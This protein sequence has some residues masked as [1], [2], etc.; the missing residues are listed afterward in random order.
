[1]QRILKDLLQNNSSFL[2]IPNPV[3]SL[4]VYYNLYALYTGLSNL[5]NL[6][7]IVDTYIDRTKF[8]D[9]IQKTTKIGELSTIDINDKN[10]IIVTLKDLKSDIDGVEWKKTEQGI[11]L[12]I[13]TVDQAPAGVKLK[14]KN[15][16]YDKIILL[17]FDTEEEISHLIN[18]NTELLNQDKLIIFSSNKSLDN[19]NRFY[20]NDN[21]SVG[22]QVYSFMK[23]F[24]IPVNKTAALYLIAGI[25]QSTNNLISNVNANTF[26]ALA[27]LSNQNAN[28]DL[29]ITLANEKIQQT[30]KPDI[31]NVDQDNQKAPKISIQN[32][33]NTVSI[34]QPKTIS[35]ALPLDNHKEENA[36][37]KP[38]TLQPK[39]E[40]VTKGL[41]QQINETNTVPLSPATNV[42]EPIRFEKVK[43]VVHP[44]TPLP[45]AHT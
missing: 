42:P 38:T 10:K 44:N 7:L 3:K 36:P 19:K 28:L 21:S 1:M 6:D 34:T 9:S 2:L 23:E 18:Q 20:T 31:T 25:Y 35:N 39:A 32:S 22:Q 16:S 29:A 17:D 37:I 30:N 24:N 40:P 27:D 14:Y 41:A 26:K 13:T 8:T 15:S 5:A 12:T 43:E 4:A 45:A 33:T 11:K